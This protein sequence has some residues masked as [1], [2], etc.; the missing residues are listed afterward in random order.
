MSDTEITALAIEVGIFPTLMAK[1]VKESK[2]ASI[3]NRRKKAVYVSVCLT[4]DMRDR[5]HV[6][7]DRLNCSANAFI[8]SVVFYYLSGTEEPAA[9]SD[10]HYGLSRKVTDKIKR[11]TA[12]LTNARVPVAMR[13]ALSLRA[14]ARG[15]TLSEAIRSLIAGVMAG[16]WPSPPRIIDHRDCPDNVDEYY[17]PKSLAGDE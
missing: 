7:L 8:R 1:C 5:F 3:R 13:L 15:I 12:P 11:G 10:I 2:A 6:L 17:L 4:P 14:R 9:G 16:T